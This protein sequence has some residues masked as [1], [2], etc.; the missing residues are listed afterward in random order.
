MVTFTGQKSDRHQLDW[1]ME[2][3]NIALQGQL[4]I[5]H[6]QGDT[7][8]RVQLQGSRDRPGK[9]HPQNE[10]LGSYAGQPSS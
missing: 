7:V 4:G 3:T 1:M 6:H 9:G 5:T 8:R 10:R 2:V